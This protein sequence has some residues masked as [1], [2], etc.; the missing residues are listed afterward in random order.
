MSED[1]KRMIEAIR[2]ARR[3][4]KRHPEVTVD[5]IMAVVEELRIT[6]T[7]LSSRLIE[8]LLVADKFIHVEPEV[9]RGY[10]YGVA[11]ELSALE[12]RL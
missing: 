10:L 6:P 7:P 3:Y 11:F 12:G 8:M 1:I 4:T 5:V 9:C 2:E